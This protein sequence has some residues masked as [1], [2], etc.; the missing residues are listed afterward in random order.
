MYFVVDNVFFVIMSNCKG[1]WLWYCL[2]LNI[3]HIYG[4][5]QKMCKNEMFPKVI[6]YG[7]L[8]QKHIDLAPFL[9]VTFFL[10]TMNVPFQSS[11]LSNSYTQSQFNYYNIS[12]YNHSQYN[13]FNINNQYNCN[14]N[15]HISHLHHND[16]FQHHNN[17]NIG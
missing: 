12:H 3:I 9:R 17:V 16:Q 5:L 13:Q 7:G 2:H 15:R 1:C 11:L 10:F 4:I 14:Y 8:S 6:I